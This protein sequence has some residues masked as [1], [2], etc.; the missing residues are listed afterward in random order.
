M[1]NL[2][3]WGGEGSR[4]W[5]LSRKEYPKQFLKLGSEKTLLQRTID[6]MKNICSFEDIFLLSGN[7]YSEIIHA[8]HPEFSKKQLLL[9]PEPRNTL[10]VLLYA[11]K[12]LQEKG[13]LDENELLIICPSDHLITPVTSFIETVRLGV[14]IANKGKIVTFGVSPTKPDTGY[15]YI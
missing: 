13:S 11:I 1:K 14:E 6:R 4:L 2:I 10:P 15:G 8:Q 5:P 12:Q 3:L 9:E 7:S